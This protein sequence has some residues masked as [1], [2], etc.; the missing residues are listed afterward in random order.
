MPQRGCGKAEDGVEGDGAADV[1]QGKGD[2]EAACCYDGVDGD[3]E[4]DVYALEP[5]GEGEA[6]VSSFFLGQWEMGMKV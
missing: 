6:V 1:D 4:L 3:V 2:G 5:A